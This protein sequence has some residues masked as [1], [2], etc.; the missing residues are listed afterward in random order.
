MTS[1][2]HDLDLMVD[3]QTGRG[4]TEDASSTP[5][6]PTEDD[7]NHRPPGQATSDDASSTTGDTSST[8]GDT[9]SNTGAAGD[10]SGTTDD[11]SGTAGGASGGSG[12]GSGMPGHPDAA[13]TGTA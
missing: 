7:A 13:D 6:T 9:S 5:R 8:T 2:D 4:S 11:A 12:G 3:T 1:M 10:A